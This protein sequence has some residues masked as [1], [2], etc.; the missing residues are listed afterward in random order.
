MATTGVLLLKTPCR[1]Q[2]F[3]VKTCRCSV[4]CRAWCRRFRRSWQGYTCRRNP[5][6]YRLL[7][8]WRWHLPFND[9]CPRGFRDDTCRTLRVAT[10][11]PRIASEYYASLCR[12]IDIIKLNGSIELAPLA[13]LS[14][15]IHRS[16][17]TGATLRENGPKPL[18][19]FL[20]LAQG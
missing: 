20:T 11:Y 12:D 17:E 16:V 9:S 18:T 2:I 13:G 4:L 6:T 1:R 7:R 14:D 15:V 3:M 8:S 5:V 10:K 19:L